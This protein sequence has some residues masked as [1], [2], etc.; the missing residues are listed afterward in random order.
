MAKIV[1]PT[2]FL[3]LLTTLAD[4]QQYSD[5]WKAVLLYVH[6]ILGIRPNALSSEY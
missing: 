3:D 2:P 5:L 4:T 1:W 6:G